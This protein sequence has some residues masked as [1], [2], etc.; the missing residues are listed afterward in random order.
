MRMLNPPI[1]GLLAVRN[2]ASMRKKFVIAYS[3]LDKHGFG[4][5]L[6]TN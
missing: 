5:F 4:A 2:L 1:G 6:F 3:V